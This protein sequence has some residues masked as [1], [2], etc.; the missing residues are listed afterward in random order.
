M[1]LRKARPRP[2]SVEANTECALHMHTLLHTCQN[3]AVT[4]IIPLFTCTGDELSLVELSKVQDLLKGLKD[5]PT[6]EPFL[7]PVNPLDYPD[8]LTIIKQPMDLDTV[9]KK[10]EQASYPFVKDVRSRCPFLHPCP[11]RTLLRRL[12][13]RVSSCSATFS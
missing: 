13:L 9:S 4:H 2:S 7:M 8:Y 6:A 12:C 10:L 11:R 3:T 5:D 1:P